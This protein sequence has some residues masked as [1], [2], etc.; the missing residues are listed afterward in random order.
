MRL[1]AIPLILLALGLVLTPGLVADDGDNGSKFDDPKD[2]TPKIPEE[3]VPATFTLKDYRLEMETEDSRFWK[4]L[5]ISQQDQEAGVVFLMQMK[6]P[7]S[8]DVFDARIVVQG[9]KHG[10]QFDFDGKKVGSDNYKAL[11]D[12]FY[13]RDIKE[14]KDV[15]DEEKPKARRLSREISKAYRYALTGNPGGLPLRKEMYL[16]KYKDKTYGMT[17]LYTT[18][19]AKNEAITGNV[20][21]M[22]KSLK[23]WKEKR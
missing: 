21:G 18:T 19:S 1:A 12:V 14:W 4:E 8:N 9:W 10:G 6:L 5:P 7:K 15:R 20:E 17:V 16:F 11:A 2:D 3:P 13:E 22:L 23:E